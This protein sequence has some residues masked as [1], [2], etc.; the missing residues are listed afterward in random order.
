MRNK[1]ADLMNNVLTVLIAVVG[2][3]IIGY[4][5]WK[6]Y[7]VYADQDATN[8]QKEIDLIEG[9]LGNLEAGQAS[10]IL[11]R[12]IPKWAIVGWGANEEGGPDKCYFKSCVCICK[13]SNLA[14]RSKEEFTSSCQNS[15]YCRTFSEPRAETFTIYNYNDINFASSQQQVL[16]FLENP[17]NYES[18][19]RLGLASLKYKNFYIKYISFEFSKTN[20]IEVDL[21]KNESYVGL[22]EV[23]SL[24]EGAIDEGL[25]PRFT[26]AG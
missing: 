17:A 4:A 10:R 2:L 20:L 6:L 24:N 23:I 16:E 13:Y 25:D 3:V 12:K 14:P 7:V 8:A 18:S 5:A 26:T 22:V 9:K 1:R 11:L 19:F 15:G 21:Y